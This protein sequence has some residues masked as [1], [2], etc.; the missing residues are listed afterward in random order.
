MFFQNLLLGIKNICIS[1]TI[2]ITQIALTMLEIKDLN[3]NKSF[4]VIL[5]LCYNSAEVKPYKLFF[6]TDGNERLSSVLIKRLN[7][8]FKPFL[9]KDLD[10]ALLQVSESQTEFI[11]ERIM[12]DNTKDNIEISDNSGDEIG[13]LA[14][15]L[16]RDDKKMKKKTNKAQKSHSQENEMGTSLH[17]DEEEYENI[18][19]IENKAR[20]D[21]STQNVEIKSN[22]RKRLTKTIELRG[23]KK[24][25][26]GAKNFKEDMSKAEEKINP[27]SLNFNALSSNVISAADIIGKQKKSKKHKVDIKPVQ[28]EDEDIIKNNNDCN[29]NKKPLAKDTSNNNN[30]ILSSTPLYKKLSDKQTSYMNMMS[31]I[32]KLK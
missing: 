21:F 29:N 5:Y 20:D 22:K 25:R 28:V 6:D 23:T 8:Y 3:A 27:T 4:N 26:I 1:H 18:N 9:K 30:K 17:L 24:S 16:H 11:W 10:L 2:G 12:A 32:I 31:P 15:F 19:V 14:E 13:F 7:K